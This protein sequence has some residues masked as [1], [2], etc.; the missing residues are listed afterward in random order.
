MPTKKKYPYAFVACKDCILNYSK[1]TAKVKM[2]Q[3]QDWEYDS[4]TYI[5]L[6]MTKCPHDG[7]PPFH[8][9]IRKKYNM[10]C[11]G[12]GGKITCPAG[13][14]RH[15]NEVFCEACYDER[16]ADNAFTEQMD[17]EEQKHF[18]QTGMDY[19][20]WQIDQH[21]RALERQDCLEMEYA[22]RARENTEKFMRI[23]F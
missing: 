7:H 22:K 13:V 14:F 20:E 19:P 23:F 10:H 2:H 6:L 5:E 12:C 11:F 3:A 16:L 18:E 4:L 9:R 1:L 21:Q 8:I 15:F 17:Y